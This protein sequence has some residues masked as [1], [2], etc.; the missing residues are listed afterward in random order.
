M[1]RDAISIMMIQNGVKYEESPDRHQALPKGDP[2]IS[3][4]N[5]PLNLTP[6]I[7]ASQRNQFN[8]VKTLLDLGERIPVPHH[9][10]CS[11]VEC[12][13]TLEASDELEIS[14]TRLFTY[15]GLA[16]EAYISL[17]SDDPILEAF[18]LRQTLR[19]NAEIEKYFKV[20]TGLE[21]Q[22]GLLRKESLF[23]KP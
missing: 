12:V 10:Y 1:D 8:V 2:C 9:A 19:K 17:N 7:L 5:F 23:S 15:R 18:Q 3:K 11:C 4:S 6:L 14:K 20:S 13:S 22:S 16:S 21:R